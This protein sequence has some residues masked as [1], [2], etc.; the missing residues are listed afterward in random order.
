MGAVMGM[1]G[2]TCAS[3]SYVI[4]S[5]T[6]DC[7]TVPLYHTYHNHTSRVGARPAVMAPCEIR[8]VC[9]CDAWS[10]LLL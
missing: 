6:Y 2:T 10:W 3:E 5:V 1:A 4:M 7:D 9:M 8:F